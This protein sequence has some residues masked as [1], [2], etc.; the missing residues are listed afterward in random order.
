M[1]TFQLMKI[2]SNNITNVHP[3]V[4]AIDQLVL[5]Q[6][7]A[8]CVIVNSDEG[9]KPGTHWFAM[10]KGKSSRSIDFFDSFGIPFVNY[11]FHLI[12]FIKRYG[13]KIRFSNKQYQSDRSLTCGMFSTYFVIER[14]KGAD[15]QTILNSFS[16]D[17]KG[18]DEL[19]KK[20]VREISRNTIKQQ[21]KECTCQECINF[22]MLESRSNQFNKKCYCKNMITCK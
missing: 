7:P 14:D 22:K 10:Y 9:Y 18:N 15:Y 8:F 16:D 17:L 1:D 11:G 5:I 21:H 20:Y 4:C 2:L 19:V 6:S 12:N 3:Y 13:G